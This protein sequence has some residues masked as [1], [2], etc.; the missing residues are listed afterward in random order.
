M[1]TLRQVNTAFQDDLPKFVTP[2]SKTFTLPTRRA[3]ARVPLPQSRWMIDLQERFDELTS[4][5]MGW[6]GYS[7][8]PVSFSCASFAANLIERLYLDGVPAPQLVPGGDGTVQLEWH[9]NQFDVEIDVLAPCE[10]TAIRRNLRTGAV[11]E[12][13]LQTDFTDLTTWI[14][15]L[16]GA[17]VSA[18][19]V[20]V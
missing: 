15:E 20:R 12:L 6:D 16:Q 7:G 3:W 1:R 13:E 4:L 5:P 17:K 8:R 18:L 19:K 10:I 9:R 2:E 14:D 11:E